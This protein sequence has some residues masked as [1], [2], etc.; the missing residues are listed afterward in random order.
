MEIQTLL[1]YMNQKK[2]HFAKEKSWFLHTKNLNLQNTQVKL[3]NRSK[4]RV[5]LWLG[6]CCA[7]VTP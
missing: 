7:F 5:Q 3:V 1:D 4:R 2:I 6:W